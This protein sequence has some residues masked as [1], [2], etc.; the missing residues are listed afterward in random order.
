MSMLKMTAVVCVVLGMWC[1][2]LA[3]E[4]VRPALPEM[5]GK[6]ELEVHD[7]DAPA[8]KLPVHLVYSRNRLSSVTAKTGVMLSLHNWGGVVWEGTPNPNKL[9]EE[10]DL[11][12]IGVSYYQ[13]GDKSAGKGGDKNGEPRPYDFGFVQ[14]MD[15]LRA[16]HYVLEG[17]KD[18][19]HPFDATRIYCTGGS[20]GGN[21]TQMANKFAPN[22][23]ACIVDLS[24]MAS[25]T[26]DIA[27]NLPGG[28]SLNARYSKDPASPAFLSPDMQQIRD[29]GNPAH[30]ALQAKSENHCKIVVSH[31]EDDT[32]CLAS[33]KHRVVDAMRTAGLDVEAHFI[34]KSDIDGKLIANAGHSVGDRTALLMHFAGKYLSPKSDEMCRLKKPNDFDRHGVV[35]YPTSGGVFAVSYAGVPV[36]SFKASK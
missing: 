7:G 3:E 29:L 15:A 27:F 12:V 31:G 8:R 34:A 21:V 22:T 11:L 28:S 10:Y 36:L 2:A 18:A 24:G 1:A 4:A 25:L 5:S 32:S 9:A 20:G 26:D 16:L 19:K 14:A 30:L 17:L 35:E 13:S 6:V 33:D 23:F